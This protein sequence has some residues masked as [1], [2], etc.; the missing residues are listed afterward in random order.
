M[1]PSRPE[2]CLSQAQIGHSTERKAFPNYSSFSLSQKAVALA[3][4]W[5]TYIA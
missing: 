5:I 2:A 3:T 4:E 1:V